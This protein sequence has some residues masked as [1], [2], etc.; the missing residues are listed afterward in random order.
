MS[1][2]GKSYAPG[3][4]RIAFIDGALANLRAIP[5]VQAAGLGS[6]MPLEGESWLEGLGRVDRPGVRLFS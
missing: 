1:L 5:G 3:P 6:A 2:A 4:A